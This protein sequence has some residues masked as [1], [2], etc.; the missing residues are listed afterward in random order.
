MSDNLNRAYERLE[1]LE[2]HLKLYDSYMG[3]RGNIAACRSLLKKVKASPDTS[4]YLQQAMELL[5][6]DSALRGQKDAV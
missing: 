2:S 4:E 6:E 1:D 5:N 3:M